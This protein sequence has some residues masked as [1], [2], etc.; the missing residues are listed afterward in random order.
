MAQ[1]R[2]AQ[3]I[4]VDTDG[5]YFIPPQTVGTAAE[6]ENLIASL[7]EILPKGID[8]ELDGRY[9]AM[10]SYKMK[11]YALLDE[12]GRLLIKGSGLRSRGLELFQR[13]W[14]EEMLTLLLS[15]ERESSDLYHRYL[16][17]LENH[18]KDITW[19]AKTETL[20]DSLESYQTKV[21]TKKRNARTLRI[22]FEITAAVS[23]GG[24]DLLLC[25]RNQSKGQNQRKLQARDPV[26]SAGS[27]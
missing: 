5:I 3:I 16:D 8:L 2:G 24:S 18:R 10:F 15:G 13:D 19:L 4:E 1:E 21:K 17:D 6:E 27:G 9:P 26:E 20:Q 23:A 12:Q 25:D 7:K 11:N 14:L 22:G